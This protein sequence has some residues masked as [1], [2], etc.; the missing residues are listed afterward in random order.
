[1]DL[2]LMDLSHKANLLCNHFYSILI[3]LKNI[4]SEFLEGTLALLLRVLKIV[5]FTIEN[6]EIS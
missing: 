6:F 2:G 4:E 5:L 1:M 3:S